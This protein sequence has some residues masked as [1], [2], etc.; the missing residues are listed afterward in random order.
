[1]P[2]ARPLLL[3]AACL[4]FLVVGRQVRCVGVRSALAASRSRQAWPCDPSPAPPLLLRVQA[5][6][7]SLREQSTSTEPAVR[8]TEVPPPSELAAAV[9]VGAM[10]APP[11]KDADPADSTALTPAPA[12]AAFDG[13]HG[14]DIGDGAMLLT[15]DYSKPNYP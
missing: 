12:P 6:A 11:R 7:R 14:V 1:M 15:G 2:P 5:A 10:E 13:L 3:W 8:P 9:E 4:A